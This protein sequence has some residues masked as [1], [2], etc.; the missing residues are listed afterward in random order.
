[1]ARPPL[2]SSLLLALVLHRDDRRFALADL[3]E[4]FEAR[5][6]HDGARRARRW[7]REQVRRSILPSLGR[8]L[9]I[10]RPLAPPRP[11]HEPRRSTLMS[12]LVR[13]LRYAFRTIG[14]SRVAFVVTIA[15]LAFG[16]G[17]VTVVFAIANALFLR[18]PAA[19]ADPEGLI[20]VYTSR[21]DG[22]LYGSTSFP[23]YLSL[24]E[25][26]DS[27]DGMAATGFD[28]LKL[29]DGQRSLLAEMVT[30][31]YFAVLGVR[32]VLG[33][34]FLPEE[35]TPGRA[36]RVV[37]ISHELWQRHFDGDPL[38]IGRTLRLNG[39]VHEIVGV[40][41][42]GLLSRLFGL[43][44]DLW[45]PLGIPGESTHRTVAELERRDDR[46]FRVFGRLRHGA[47][48]GGVR[49][50]LA[51]VESRLRSA[52]P[53]AWKDPRG[54][55][56]RLS[57]LSERDSRV[58]PEVRG[59]FAGVAVFFLGA[60]GLILLIACSNVMGLFLAQAGRRRREIAVRLALGASRRRIVAML[61][62]EGLVPGLL[63]GVLGMLLASALA[64][65][66]ESIPL[67]FGVPL[68]F[69][70]SPDVRVLGFALLSAVGA[71]LA[72][73]L[74]PALQASRPELA[75]ALKSDVPG[76]TLGRRRF[77]L[78]NAIVVVQFAT[79]VVLLAGAVLFL[80]SLQGA[81]R[82]DFGIDTDRVAIM[83]RQ[84]PERDYT[85]ETA[86]A[87]IRG[88]RSRLEALPGVEDV[89]VSRG[90][91]LTLAQIGTEVRVG[92]EGAAAD[93]LK[94]AFRNSVTAGYLEMLGVPIVRGR[95]IAERDVSGAPRV[96]VINETMAH[97]LWPDEDPIGRR[98]LLSQLRAFEYGGSEKPQAFEVV[99]VARD[100]KYL[101]ID[102]GPLSYCWTA[103]Y[104]DYTPLV[105]VTVKGVDSAEA[106]VPLLREHG[107]ASLDEVALIAPSTLAS[108][109][110]VQFLPLR[111]AA[112]V[113]GWGGLFGLA[114]ALV[115]IYGV[116]TYA[117]AMRTREMA[118]RFAIGAS[119][120]QV[121]GRIVRDAMWLA[122]AGLTLGLL[123]VAPLAPLAK[124]LLFGVSPFDPVSFGGT[125]LVLVGAALVASLVP[126]RRALTIDPIQV[127]RED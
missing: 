107:E 25:S 28:G 51:V 8:R 32:P 12:Q 4:E 100:G 72:F 119:A 67:P 104:Q 82:T 46:E 45:V 34:A 80:R 47:S 99:G 19:I 36:R 63:S 118:I 71:S 102:D 49:A 17:A 90:V 22:R 52:Y 111:V 6:A 76:L 88:L 55:P 105:A 58:D 42:E 59:V 57:V 114:L 15:S 127:L 54:R 113:L 95:T 97:R 14:R 50:Q 38:V 62:T 48:I 23:D 39:H 37:V 61:V 69:D 87:Y 126:A 125:A 91:E 10:R 74:V 92:A 16:I 115:G 110:S 73:S 11:F 35:T 77:S 3:A 79:T 103:L 116:V 18:P 83:T 101:D 20:A 41:P 60:A 13:D 29:D 120:R 86:A 123:V 2:T 117:V 98:F 75:P 96:A 26:L 31:N 40:A 81:L 66:I 64:S 44:P 124:S 84:L 43:R 65:A 93:E 121:L 106:M 56:R 109:V 94:T 112:R 89:Q 30:G 27:L 78:R 122:V 21:D 24:A 85:P 68:R 7:Y 1:M 5:V 70:F 108:Q 9:H 53:D 33:R